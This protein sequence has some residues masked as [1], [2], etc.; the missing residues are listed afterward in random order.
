MATFLFSFDATITASSANPPNLQV[1]VGGVVVSSLVLDPTETS[2]DLFVEF[3]GTA[4]SSLTIRF[5]PTS[6]SGSDSI[7][8]SS[9]RIN[10]TVITTDLTATLLAQGQSSNVNAD[11]VVFGRETPTLNPADVSGT[12][13]D[14]DYVLSTNEADSIDG[15]AGNDRLRGRGGDDDINGGDG[16]DFIFGEAGNDT[17]LGGDGNDIIFGN[18]GDDVILG[19]GGNDTLLGGAD[20]DVLNGGVGSD[21]LLGEAGDD[22]IFGEDDADYLVGGA[23]NDIL[24]GDDGDDYV[25]GDDGDDALSGGSGNDFLVGGTGND[26]LGGGD[27]DDEMHGE[28]GNDIFNGNA[29]NDRIFG[30]DGDDE[31]LGGADDDTMLGGDGNDVFDGE[32]GNDFIN[33]GAGA[34]TLSGGAD[35]DILHGHGLDSA[36][37]SDILFNNP[38]VVYSEATGS[39]YQYVD[40]AVNYAGAVSAATSATIN[41]V[42]GHLATITSAAEN[43]Y[44]QG[45]LGG[46]TWM[47]GVDVGS[48]GTWQW[49]GGPEAGLQF[50][51]VTGAAVFGQFVNWDAGQPQNNTE[52][53]SVIYQDGSWH[54]WPD[55]STHRYVIEWESSLFSDDNAIDTIDGGDG[56]DWVYGYG[57]NDVLVGGSGNDFLFGGL[58]D[59]TIDGGNGGDT[60]IGGAGADDINAG[61]NNDNILL[62]NGDFAAGESING[63]ANNDAL[64]L[65]N[66]T[67]VDFSTGT[68]NGLETL[69]GSFG[70]DTI[71]LSSTQWAGFTTID[72]GADTDTVNVLASGDISASGT[73]TVSNSEHGYLIGTGGNDTTVM[74]GSQ[75][76]AIIYGNGTINLGGGTDSLGITTTSS[77]LNTFG[78]GDDTAITNTETISATSATAGVT[79]DLS[80]QT[81]SF[82][83]DGGSFADNIQSGA[84]D[85]VI[86]GGAGN[87]TI[88]GDVLGGTGIQGWDYEY[89]DFNVALAT[90]AEAGFTLNGGRDNSN[91]PTTTGTATNFDPSNFDAG[92]EF[93]LK[94]TAELTVVTG[95]TYTFRTS[96]DD[97]SELFIDGVEIVSNDGLHG[98]ATVTSAGQTLS[99]GTYLIEITYFENG[100]GQVL[101][102]EISGPDTGG[103][104]VTLSNFANAAIPGTTGTPTDSDDV[105]DGGSG[106]DEIYGGIGSDTLNGGD[107]D[108]TI[109]A[110]DATTNRDSLGATYAVGATVTDY[111][112]N[113]NT[114]L[115][116]YV[117]T[118]GNDPGNVT[119]T[120][121]R[122][123]ND[124]N[125]A[126][127]ALEVEIE[128]SNGNFSNAFGYF[129]ETI[130]FTQDLQNAELS[131]FYRHIHANQNDNGEDSSVFY[132]L[133]STVFISD[134]FGSGGAFDSDWTE[135][136]VSLGDVSAGDSI[137]LILGIIH[138]GSSRNNEDATAR[139][140]DIAVTGDPLIYTPGVSTQDADAAN[141]NILNG[142]AGNDTLYGSSGNDTLNGDAGADDIYSG[143]VDVLS[144]EITS[145][146]A[147]NPNISYNYD[148]GNF[149]Q[150]VDN[151]ANINWNTAAGDSASSLLNGVAGHL[152]TITSAT[153][154]AFAE[155]LAGGNNTWLGGRDSGTEGV[156]TWDFGGVENGAQF[157]GSTGNA[158]NGWYNN[159]AGGQPNDGDGT[160]DYLYMLNGTT[161]ADGLVIGGSGFVDIEAYL[162]EWEGADVFAALD[163][164]ILNG[165]T[166]ADTLYGSDGQDIFLFDNIS[167]IDT[168]EN[169]NAL[170]RDAL[171]ISDILS[172]DPLTDDIADF[173]QLTEVGGNTIVSVDADGT[174]G[175]TDIAQLSGT[176]GLDLDVMITAENLIVI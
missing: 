86:D 28:A 154:Q 159:W 111:S 144:A 49:S 168:I 108:D 44:I 83:I 138:Y 16:A 105:I 97:G 157:A 10:N 170:G 23:G 20:A 150:W 167:N 158:V 135:Y 30:G 161:W 35:N 84:G 22:V 162:I 91:T 51:D 110:L 128:N 59:D 99:P 126:D 166:G 72:T 19:E 174:G 37:I 42:S 47:G 149:Y 70:V 74:T 123:T 75:L 33:G 62:A 130:T 65:T 133:G 116:G 14:D 46:T 32:T 152:A 169:F 137:D 50:S 165:G 27:G 56:D 89:Y 6:G 61:G 48:N 121:S 4:P 85:D 90:L 143:T 78:A 53:W 115:D 117:Y 36:T 17:I 102:A 119:V 3:S 11:S 2:F 38:G 122:I 113:F 18:E 25:I 77:I 88:Y 142:G 98:T 55:T 151:G 96:S 94:F 81:E 156:W 26:L 125:L 114:G 95:G 141:A 1:L 164:N 79:I 63:G 21:T 43:T 173:V 39:F 80:A 176:T 145:L 147:A 131:F 71:T 107:D 8:I 69:T 106:N 68:L 64:I 104:F 129:T 140:D 112:V 146:L 66:A 73:P 153:E 57:G 139:F 103:S 92:D 52:Y 5:D 109:F 54:D 118:D 101:D 7:N 24:F 172:Y 148:T 134:A 175:F 41:G 67:T 100:G 15:L 60:I 29:G 82:D 9:A 120:G 87:D 136:T 76:D 12:S 124:G 160:Q 58:G 31:A 163:N 127:G 34:D 40:T 132:N 45:L 155:S 13:G 171:D 93:A